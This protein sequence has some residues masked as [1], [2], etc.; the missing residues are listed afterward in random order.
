MQ[1]SMKSAEDVLRQCQNNE[2]RLSTLNQ[3][4]GFYLWPY[5]IRFKGYKTQQQLKK[6]SIFNE[7]T[8]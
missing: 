7:L 2:D 4:V 3:T 1:R 6:K 8:D 5:R